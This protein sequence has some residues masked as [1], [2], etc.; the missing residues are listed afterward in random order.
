[1]T[2][3]ESDVAA[4]EALVQA[5]YQKPELTAVLDIKPGHFSDAHQRKLWETLAAFHAEGLVPHLHI[6]IERS[7]V[8]ASIAS[9]ASDG[10]VGN[11]AYYA[12]MVRSCAVRRATRRVIEHSHDDIRNGTAT[13]DVIGRLTM[14]LSKLT[15]ATGA[16]YQETKEVMVSV[17]DSAEHEFHGTT[18]KLLTGI[19]RLDEITGGMYPGELIVLGARPS[20]GKSAL[21]LQLA[22]D[23]AANKVATGYESLE[24]TAVALGRR[25]LAGRA[26]VEAGKLRGGQNGQKLTTADFGKLQ[27]AAGPL[28]DL[29]LYFADRGVERLPE[30]LMMARVWIAR[31]SIRLLVVDYLTLVVPTDPRMEFR[32]HVGQVT[33]ELKKLARETGLVV[34]LVAQLRRPTGN[35]PPRLHDLRESGNIEQDADQVWLLHRKYAVDGT[36]ELDTQLLVAKHREGSTGAVPLRFVPGWVRFDGV[37]G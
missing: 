16:H 3:P 7:G 29:P 33:R 23:L 15:A 11:V 14:G 4:E 24:M 10:F 2:Y 35:D 20:V 30:L 28:A 21:A 8:P 26:H 25:L 9:S 32:H 19:Y 31:H 1:M 17:I 34:L 27:E 13:T 12:D 37:P 18:G 22:A 36:L 5:A 6:L